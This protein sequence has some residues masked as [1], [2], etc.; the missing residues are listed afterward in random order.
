MQQADR[1][2]SASLIAEQIA[3]R[4]RNATQHETSWQACCPAHEDTDPSLAITPAS[5]KVL[6]H[7]F[8]GCTVEA[9][10]AALGLTVADLFLAPLSSR[11]GKRIVAIYS[12]VD[13]MGQVLHETVRFEPKDFSQ[14][15]PDPVTPGAYIWK[16]VFTGIT[17]VLYHLPEV[18]AAMQRGEMIYI[19]EGEKDADALLARGRVATCNP[20]GAGKWRKSYAQILRGAHCRILPDNDASGRTH[21]ED[22]A[23]SLNGVAASV[24]II[25][26]PNLP[27]R[28]DVSDWL[29][30]G[31]TQ[32]DFDA[33]IAAAPVWTSAASQA[34]SAS[35]QDIPIH[36]DP[37][38]RAPTNDVI[39][40]LKKPKG[41]QTWDCVRKDLHDT[42]LSGHQYAL[43]LLALHQGWSD[44]ALC[45]DRKSV[46]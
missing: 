18:L 15:R 34:I 40:F 17:P 24:K 7:C 11:N 13:A 43:A 16:N 32:A 36:F 31:G 35:W 38:A 23:R 3:Q 9:I 19:V 44:Q 45:E 26:L 5:D 20:M 14:R 10:V 30:A 37:A 12:Y 22:I 39:A 29:A 41:Q 8:A 2:I 21:A 27:E 46:V 4:C 1:Q 25:P 42:S 28:G 33:L 6:L